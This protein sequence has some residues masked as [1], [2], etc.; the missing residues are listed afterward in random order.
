MFCRFQK[1]TSADRHYTLHRLSAPLTLHR[2]Q[3]LLQPHRRIATVAVRKD[4]LL[5]I[6]HCNIQESHTGFQGFSVQPVPTKPCGPATRDATNIVVTGPILFDLTI[7]DRSIV[8]HHGRTGLWWL[9]DGSWRCRNSFSMGNHCAGPREYSGK[10]P[11]V[12]T[13]IPRSLP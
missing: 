7:H 4:Q 9:Q 8:I 1:E 6:I 2:G 5:R 3:A 12:L 11:T 13:Q 10:L